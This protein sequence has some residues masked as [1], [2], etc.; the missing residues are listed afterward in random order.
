[1]QVSNETFA[2]DPYKGQEKRLR[3]IFSGPGGG[4]ERTWDESDTVRF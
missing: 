3:I 2:F 4:Y 1:M